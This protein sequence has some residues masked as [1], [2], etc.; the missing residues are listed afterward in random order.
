MFD[1]VLSQTDIY[2]NMK[3]NKMTVGKMTL[4]F[5]NY[6]NFNSKILA[7]EN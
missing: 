7:N 4:M 3:M 1:A 6:F 2:L 5:S